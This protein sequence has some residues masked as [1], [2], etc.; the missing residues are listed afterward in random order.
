MKLLDFYSYDK[1]NDLRKKMN[2]DL[3]FW[4]ANTQWNAFDPFGFR[5]SLREKGEVEIPFDEIKVNISDKTLE[6][7]GEKILVYIRDQRYSWETNYKFHIANCRT[8]IDAQNHNR[9][10]KYVAS[11]NTNGIFK[12]NII[13]GSSVDENQEIKLKVCKNCLQTINYKNYR[14]S[15]YSGKMKIYQNFSIEEYF[16]IYKKQNI[17]KP[18]HTNIT[19]PLNNYTDDFKEIANKLKEKHN[20]ICSK[21][22]RD[23]SADKKFLHVHHKDGIKSNNNTENLEVLCI[24]CHAKEYNH[25]HIKNLPDYYEY[26]MKYENKLF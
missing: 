17:K 14:Y 21:C 12:V 5:A 25:S 9:Y 15:N 7:F 3:I 16:N 22:H 10:K 24:A 26:K 18:I 8:L 4:E 19:A 20:Y 6:L 1:L 23:F 2:A 13:H 11:I